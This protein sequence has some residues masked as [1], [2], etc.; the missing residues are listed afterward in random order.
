MPTLP[1]GRNSTQD[2]VGQ[3]SYPDPR[4]HRLLTGPSDS[5]VLAPPGA[6]RGEL[7]ALAR[8]A[9]RPLQRTMRVDHRFTIRRQ[10]PRSGET[11]GMRLG[12]LDQALLRQTL[13]HPRNLTL[14]PQTNDLRDFTIIQTRTT[15]N[16]RQRHLLTRRQPV[17]HRGDRTQRA[18]RRATPVPLLC[19]NP[20]HR[21]LK[22][23][24]CGRATPV[25]QH[26]RRHQLTQQLN[27][28]L[29]TQLQ[30][31]RMNHT[32]RPTNNTL[33]NHHRQPRRHPRIHTTPVNHTRQTLQH[34]RPARQHPR[35]PSQRLHKHQ[36]PHHRL[37]IKCLQQ[38][39]QRSTDS[40]GPPELRLP[41]PTN[42]ELQTLDRV[43]ERRQKTIFPITK[44]PVEH[45]TR[46]PSTLTDPSHRHTL[47]TTLANERE[48]RAQQPATLQTINTLGP[49]TGVSCRG[50][51]PARGLGSAHHDAPTRERPTRER[52]TREREIP[53]PRARR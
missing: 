17:I 37:T 14:I 26:D 5:F 23:A 40:R 47:I 3:R 27:Q 11:F 22:L 7:A 30:Q 15:R 20:R 8:L 16:S 45:T 49:P 48:R 38:R 24:R 2:L 46:H 52:P 44:R 9:L 29:R 34:T 21:T 10:P 28:R 18:P 51:K 32:K 12:V 31:P 1:Q 50:P 43:V 6:L 33:P 53:H 41:T 25:G 42:L 4:A 39:P 36:P 19:G 35:T 13:H